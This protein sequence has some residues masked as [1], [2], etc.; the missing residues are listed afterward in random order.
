[1]TLSHRPLGELDLAVSPLAL[2][3]VK[4]GR[5]H[6]VKYPAAFELPE[7]RE[8]SRLLSQAFDQGI[9]LID[10]APAYGTSET[11]IGKLL[12]TDRKDW[13]ICTKAGEQFDG[14]QSRYDYSAAAMNHSIDQSL[15][16]LQTDYLDIVLVHS[17]GDD[18]DILQSTDAMATLISRQQAGDIRYIG[19]SGKT[20]EGAQAAIAYC[21]VLMI[22]LNLADQTH[23]GVIN[24]ASAQGKGILIKKALDSGHANPTDNLA[25]ALSQ[26]G[27]SSVV[28]GTINPRHLSENIRIATEVLTTQSS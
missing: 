27:V 4:F 5:N 14:S 3:S 21:D 26:P 15:K 23:L 22:T 2:G 7:D 12:P 1:M 25:F 9:N 17:N 24:Q 19:F 16:A 28:I 6:G 11:R 18:L 10:T 8:V 13:V 20:V